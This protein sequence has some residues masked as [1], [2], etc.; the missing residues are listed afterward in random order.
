MSSTS[1]GVY[2][3]TDGISVGQNSTN[4]VKLNPSDGSL[5]ATNANISGN[6]TAT[7]G[8]IAGFTMQ[9]NRIYSAP[10]SSSAYDSVGLYSG[11]G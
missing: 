2:V 9:S 7:T 4:Y 1:C 5:T 8:S 6:I 11:S 3:G 10:S